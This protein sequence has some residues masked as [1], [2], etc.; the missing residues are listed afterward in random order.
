MKV[1]PFILAILMSATLVYAAEDPF[2][3]PEKNKEL[4]NDDLVYRQTAYKP[5]SREQ[6]I[7]TRQLK[8]K[9]GCGFRENSQAR[10]GCDIYS[11]FERDHSLALRGG[12]SEL[13][14]RSAVGLDLRI[15]W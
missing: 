7:I 14:A 6:L 8:D 11:R 13:S 4:M 9:T 3:T 10:Y 12:L 15:E 5:A 1:L 2:Q